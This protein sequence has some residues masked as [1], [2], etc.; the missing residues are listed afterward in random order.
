MCPSLR[1]ERRQ[2]SQQTV[3]CPGQIIVH[4]RIIHKILGANTTDRWDAFS[5]ENNF[6]NQNV[7]PESLSKCAKW[8]KMWRRES[9]TYKVRFFVLGNN[10]ISFPNEY[11]HNGNICYINRPPPSCNELIRFT[12]RQLVSCSCRPR[13]ERGHIIS[14]SRHASTSGR[15]IEFNG[16]TE[17]MSYENQTKILRMCVCFNLFDDSVSRYPRTRQPVLYSYAS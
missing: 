7:N 13:N 3:R 5:G 9:R 2:L 14:R 10:N 4:R 1:G 6:I 12:C 15:E 17:R 8:W 16:K 11:I